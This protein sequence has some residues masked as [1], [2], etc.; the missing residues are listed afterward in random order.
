MT[1]K[2]RNPN[3]GP[4][5]KRCQHCGTLRPETKLAERKVEG[6]GGLEG[7]LLACLDEDREWCERTRK[8]RLLRDP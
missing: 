7:K 3:D 5:W 1:T 8:E 2:V 4:E 6:D